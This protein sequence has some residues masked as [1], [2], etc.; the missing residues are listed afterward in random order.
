M[1]QPTEQPATP[2]PAPAHNLSYPI[3]EHPISHFLR[4]MYEIIK[5]V[6]VVLVVAL[7]IRYFLV[8][9]FI[10]DGSSMEPTFHNHEYLIVEKVNY[11]VH[12]PA[13]GDIIVFK[14]PL[15][16]SLNYVK[17]VI[18]VPGDR[19][20]IGDGKVTVYNNSY[21]NG[22][23]LR[24]PY[25]QEDQITKVNGE[26][27]DRTWVV[28]DNRYFVMGD[29]RDHSDDSRSWGLVPKENIVG[30]AWMTIYPVYDFG[31]VEHA[32]Y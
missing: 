29:N 15:N 18:G 13:R 28:D 30:R 20:T 6:V 5:T 3:A 22:L 4:F 9:P 17:R 27:K 32:T 2:E 21:P 1:D 25:L 8:Q 19:V 23:Q 12:T 11:T 14:Y 26:E 7:I 24:E 10:V 31:T 16:P